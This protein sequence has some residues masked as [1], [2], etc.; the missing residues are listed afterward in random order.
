MFKSVGRYWRVFGTGLSFVAVGI[1]GVFVF[2]ALN[3]LIRNRARRA[4]VARHVI[5][6]TF[7]CIVGFMRVLG[8]FQY[9]ITGSERLQR[10]GLLILANHPTLIDIVFLIAFVN[11][12]DCIV[13]S[14]LWRNPFTHATVRAAA[15]VRNDE[16]GIRVIEDCVASVRGGSNLIIFP[17][18]TR[19]VAD[20]PVTLKRGAANIA[21]RASRNITPV[22]IQCTP[23][24][25]VKG[26]KWWRLPSPASHFN[27]E[28]K[29]DI[30]VHPFIAAAGSDVL[31]ARH[32]TQHLR[33]YFTEENKL[34]GV[35]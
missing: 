19:T 34:H 21:V 2:P 35:A 18:G 27:I 6:F 4:I 28:V 20:G 24:M 29:E 15:Y 16:D 17:E 26:E 30:D 32:L 9:Q 31:A 1:G 7:R 14:A 3:I 11:R 22:L 25:L 33:N 23:P 8:V 13:K 5:K 12:G 10:E